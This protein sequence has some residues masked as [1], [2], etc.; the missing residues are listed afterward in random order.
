[1]AIELR[2]GKFG[3]YFYDTELNGRYGDLSLSEVCVRL[4]NEIRL[5]LE[6]END[7]LTEWLKSEF[8]NCNRKYEDSKDSD[9]KRA[10]SIRQRAMVDVLRIIK[11]QKRNK[12][13]DLELVSTERHLDTANIS[14]KQEV[15]SSELTEWIKRNID[16]TEKATDDTTMPEASRLIEMGKLAA[17]NETL[18]FLGTLIK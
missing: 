5:K 2:Y 18:D 17:Y 14:E 1:M 15:K 12:E 13:S 4:N 11:I 9:V 8:D 16:D 10:W 6:L 3:P 7:K